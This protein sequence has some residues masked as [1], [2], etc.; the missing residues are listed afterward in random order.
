MDKTQPK[1]AGD[2]L[3]KAGQSVTFQYRVLL[4]EGAPDAAKLAERFDAYAQE[5]S[6]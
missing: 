5:T 2:F 6:N 1:G 3:L 4:H